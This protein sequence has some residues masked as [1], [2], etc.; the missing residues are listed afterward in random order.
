MPSLTEITAGLSSYEP[1]LVADH[2][3]SRAAV[4]VIL[5]EGPAG[6]ELLFTLRSV[7]PVEMVDAV[8]DRPRAASGPPRSRVLASDDLSAIF[9]VDIDVGEGRQGRPAPKRSRRRPAS[10][11]RPAG[12][13][14]KGT[15]RNS[16]QKPA[17]S[18]KK[19]AR[20]K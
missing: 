9:G 15:P 2:A 17:V 20:K 14:A 12:A 5:R 10:A 1:R 18:G 19:A 11:A 16:R 3:G 13:V 4:A 8:V 6:T 7:D